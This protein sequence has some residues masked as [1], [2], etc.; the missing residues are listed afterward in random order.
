MQQLGDPVLKPF[1]QDVVQFVPLF[2]TLIKTGIRHP[3]VVLKILPQVGVL[4]LMDWMR[5]AINLAC[6]SALYPLGQKLEPWVKTL[7]PTQAYY[8]HRQIQA[9][10][11][12]SGGDYKQ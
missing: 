2:Q 1:L 7:S 11:Y 4:T 9:W 10:K 6:Y 3:G 5:H 12:G 8:W